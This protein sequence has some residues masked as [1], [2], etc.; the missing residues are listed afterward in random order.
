[1]GKQTKGLNPYLQPQEGRIL[2]PPFYRQS[3]RE[4]EDYIK[5][6]TLIAYLIND[7]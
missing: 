6:K 2:A 5:F 4:G 7:Q 3:K 1:M